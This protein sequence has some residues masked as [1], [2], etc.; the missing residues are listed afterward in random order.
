MLGNTAPNKNMTMNEINN[1]IHLEDEMMSFLSFIG[2]SEKDYLESGQIHFKSFFELK[3]RPSFLSNKPI[4]DYSCGHDRITRYITKMLSPEKLV[5]A[6]VW[7]GAVNFCAKQF[8]AVPFLISKNNT[9]SKLG[10]KYDLIL[11]YSVFSHL[12]P[13]VLNANGILLFT[14][15]GNY[16]SNLHKLLLNEGF[17]YSSLGKQSNRT[18]GRLFGDEYSFMC[19]TKEYVK[20]ILDKIGLK[21]LDHVQDINKFSGQELYVVELKKYND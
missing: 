15:H 14:T 10:L 21:L 4:L 11:S 19:V 17:H 16:H 5:V 6:D 1:I 9:M 18:V 7:D 20:K 2:K 13:K 12:P 3:K 8:N